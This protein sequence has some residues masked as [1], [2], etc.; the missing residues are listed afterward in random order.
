MLLFKQLNSFQ[1][2]LVHLEWFNLV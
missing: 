2:E 1:T